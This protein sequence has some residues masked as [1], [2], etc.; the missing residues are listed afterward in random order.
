[1][2]DS[3]VIHSGLDPVLQWRKALGYS[4][5]NYPIDGPLGNALRLVGEG[6]TDGVELQSLLTIPIPINTGR[7][8]SDPTRSSPTAIVVIGCGGTGSHLVPNVVQLA[9]SLAKSTNTPMPEI[10]LI[11][12]DQV[13]ERNLLRQKFAEFE[14]GL[15]KAEALARRYSEAWPVTISYYKGYVTRASLEKLL[16]D[17]P[18]FAYDSLIIMGAVDNHNTRIQID[19]YMKSLS[20]FNAGAYWIDGGNEAHHGQAV[21]GSNPHSSTRGNGLNT[22]SRRNMANEWES[23]KIGQFIKPYAI[24]TFLDRHC[25]EIDESSLSR[26]EVSCLELAEIDPQTIQA[27]MMSAYCMTSLLSQVLLG[28]ISTTAIYF[29]CITGNTSPRLITK[30]TILEDLSLKE[31][32]VDIVD[33]LHKISDSQPLMTSSKDEQSQTQESN[34]EGLM[35]ESREEPMCS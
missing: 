2:L 18:H 31:R 25:T 6:D 35:N 29:D 19:S 3:K 27:N 12:G 16:G 30:Q 34:E 28:N 9:V 5:S 7:H 4:Y 22:E 8:T 10:F 24:P 15:N 13:E 20:R 33:N 1:M 14:V 11:D 32:S 17:S 23:A 26:K 21:L